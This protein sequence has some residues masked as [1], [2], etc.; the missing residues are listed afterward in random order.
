MVIYAPGYQN[1]PKDVIL[2]DMVTLHNININCFILESLIKLMFIYCYFS[3]KI[4]ENV[5][6][7]TS[8]DFPI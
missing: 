8:F 3:F 4:I 1:G 2:P 7:K 6:F 5:P